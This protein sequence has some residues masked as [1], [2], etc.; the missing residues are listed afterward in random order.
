MIKI[1]CISS[2]DYRRV[3][4]QK[5][6]KL[7]SSDN[8]DFYQVG[9]NSL[10]K[11]YQYKKLPADGGFLLQLLEN[12]K[13][14]LIEQSKISD[15]DELLKAEELWLV[16]GYLKGITMPIIPSNMIDFEDYITA[17]G[18]NMGE[19]CEKFASLNAL[20][21]KGS[22]LGLVFLDS[23]TKGN[24]K[25]NPNTSSILF[26]DGEGI[27][28]NQVFPFTATDFLNLDENRFI[29]NKF[30][31]SNRNGIY[32]TSNTNRLIILTYFIKLCTRYVWIT[33]HYPDLPQQIAME[34]VLNE[35]GLAKDEFL[36]PIIRTIF[37]RGEIPKIE[38]DRWQEFGRAYT[39][40]PASYG[41]VKDGGYAFRRR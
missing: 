33:E 8:S 17:C 35:I 22:D 23:T 3:V 36:A 21:E 19:I 25:M 34:F 9:F 11:D 13:E 6:R 30:L 20:F 31:K 7:F 15:F 37:G 41:E 32:A 26:C 28:T 38:S 5:G 1:N 16:D 24:L 12:W 18:T 40:V 10:L 29:M 4:L 2:R 27:Q 39:L 14:I